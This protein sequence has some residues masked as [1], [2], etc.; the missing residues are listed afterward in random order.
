MSYYGCPIRLPAAL[1]GLE[2]I[3]R[4]CSILLRVP[5]RLIFQVVNS[6]Y[7]AIKFWLHTTNSY[8][9]HKIVYF[10][11]RW[12]TFKV[13]LCSLLRKQQFVFDQDFQMRYYLSLQI[14]VLKT[15]WIEGKEQNPHRNFLNHKI[16]LCLFWSPLSYKDA[17]KFGDSCGI[18]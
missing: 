1:D 13:R 12:H 8:V 14:K 2:A 16:D 4:S 11:R 5:W 6:T 18:S 9:L 3:L 17:Y 7:A 15:L 10:K